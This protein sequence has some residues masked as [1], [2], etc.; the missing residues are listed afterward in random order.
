MKSSKWKSQIKIVCSLV[1]M[2]MLLA[3]V[4]QAQE[5]AGQFSS[6][7]EFAN[8]FL[9]LPQAFRPSNLFN[10]R[11]RHIPQ[12]KRNDIEESYTIVLNEATSGSRATIEGLNLHTAV[13]ELAELQQPMGGLYR[14]CSEESYISISTDSPECEF[15]RKD[16]SHPIRIGDHEFTAGEYRNLNAVGMCDFSKLCDPTQYDSDPADH[17][18]EPG[19]GGGGVFGGL[20]DM[21]GGGD[22]VYVDASG[23]RVQYSPCSGL[24]AFDG[25]H[26][27]FQNG[28]CVNVSEQKRSQAAANAQIKASKQFCRDAGKVVNFCDRIGLSFTELYEKSC[29]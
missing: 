10:C 25:D 3:P 2:L 17:Y 8:T 22:P 15:R 4:T 9:S 11:L 14:V 1:G 6:V 13:S 19:R 27:E 23:N 24:G 28:R 21:L 18:R 29:D 12:D 20:K 16:K 26:Y 5:V 7:D